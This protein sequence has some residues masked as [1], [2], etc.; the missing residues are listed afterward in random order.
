MFVVHALFK[1]HLVSNGCPNKFSKTIK[2]Y[3]KILRKFKSAIKTPNGNIFLD[4]FHPWVDK[5]E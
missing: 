5:F 4:K 2:F 3:L 1:I